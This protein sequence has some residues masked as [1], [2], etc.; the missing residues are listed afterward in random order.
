MKNLSLPNPYTRHVCLVVGEGGSKQKDK[1]R[2]PKNCCKK[3]GPLPI[4]KYLRDLRDPWDLT[5]PTN[6]RP[7]LLQIL[8]HPMSS[9]TGPSCKSL[10]WGSRRIVIYNQLGCSSSG[11]HSYIDERCQVPHKNHWPWGVCIK[12]TLKDSLQRDCQLGIET[13]EKAALTHKSH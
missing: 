13:V 11:G 12:S 4:M 1:G 5:L 9:N 7:D 6:R 2:V 3:C 10:C 8:N